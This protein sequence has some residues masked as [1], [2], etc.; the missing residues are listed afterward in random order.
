MIKRLLMAAAI[1]ATANATSFAALDWSWVADPEDYSVITEL[2]EVKVTFPNL[3]S[4]EVLDE[5]MI[6][7]MDDFYDFY[8]CTATAQGN[9]LTIVT[10]DIFTEAGD[11]YLVVS[12]ASI[13]GTKGLVT[14][15]LSARQEFTI[16]YTIEGEGGG[17]NDIDESTIFEFTSEPAEG[18]ITELST[19]KVTFPNIDDMDLLSKDDIELTYNGSPMSGLTFTDADDNYFKVT[20]ATPAI[21]PGVYVL[22]CP[23]HSLEAY[24]D[25]YDKSMENSEAVVLSWTI[26]KAA[27]E[28]DFS[29]IATPGNATTHSLLENVKIDFTAITSVTLTDV[30]PVVSLGDVTLAS[31]KYTVAA[32]ANSPAVNVAFTP[33]LTPADGQLVTIVFPVGSLKG[34]DP[35]ATNTNKQALTL[36]YNLANTV[37]HDL[38]IDFKS[39]TKPNSDGEISADKQLTAFF[40][41][42]ATAGLLPV[43]TTVK[44]VK[45]TSDDPEIKYSAEATL[46]KGYGF[47]SNYSYFSADFGSQEPIFN[48]SYTVTIAAD[49][50]GDAEWIA[51]H[52]F[53][54]TND[55]II[56]HFTLVDGQGGVNNIVI[57]NVNGT[58]YNMQGINLG[59]DLNSLPNGLYIVNGKVIKK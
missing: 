39:P 3:D 2:H 19:I 23:S 44:N 25:G 52:E 13:S 34:T 38:T 24:Y 21:N 48:G 11:Y 55:E 17:G 14:E 29:F 18:I 27:G 43:E 9:V 31:D 15:S 54:H 20:L 50:F 4:V 53:G 40:F 10:D 58:I 36:V 30:A 56:L 51:N 46:A 37:Q 32:D 1:A 45:I 16:L 26:E 57:D 41:E 47:N 49:S 59:N 5:S 33:A 7:V 12:E 22:T 42:A 8:D 35:E 28:L 6:Y